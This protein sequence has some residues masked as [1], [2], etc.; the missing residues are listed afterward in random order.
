MS[1]WATV[2]HAVQS[3]SGSY[4]PQTNLLTL[5]WL[6][7]QLGEQSRDTLAELVSIWLA[8]ITA[9]VYDALSANAAI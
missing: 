8:R 6:Q 3:L 7:V 2:V 5:C 1:A 4:P 9:F